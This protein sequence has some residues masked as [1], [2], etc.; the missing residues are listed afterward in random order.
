MDSKARRK[1]YEITDAS[2]D[3]RGFAWASGYWPDETMPFITPEYLEDQREFWIVNGCPPPGLVICNGRQKAVKWPDM[4][5]SGGGGPNLFV[6]EKVVDSLNREGIPVARVTEISIG[7][8]EAKGL[9]DKIPPKYFVLEVEPGIH[10]NYEASLIPLDEHGVPQHRLRPSHF[11]VWDIGR[12]ETWNGADLFS[13]EGF[14][15]L[16]RSRL[17]CTDRIVELA[18]RDKW[19]NVGFEPAWAQ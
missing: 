16:I 12:L 3:T 7:E 5:G 9:Q 8:I 17:L 4:L 14:P 15:L 19:T 11:G 6:S 13:M 1:F 2:N 18:K 10:L